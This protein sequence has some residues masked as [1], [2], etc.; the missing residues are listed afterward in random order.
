MA[1][2]LAALPESAYRRAGNHS[3]RGTVTLAELVAGSTTHVDH[4]L[5]FVHQKRAAMGKEMW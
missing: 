1:R 5:K 2:V 4:H 3:E